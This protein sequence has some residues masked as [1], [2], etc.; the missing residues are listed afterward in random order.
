MT[1]FNRNVSTC[2]LMNL[3]PSIGSWASRNYRILTTR[4]ALKENYGG[5]TITLA[6]T[7]VGVVS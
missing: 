6:S 1:S 5:Y 3:H 2:S 4:D 7:T